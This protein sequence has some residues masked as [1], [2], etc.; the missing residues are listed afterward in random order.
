MA[1][2]L[3]EKVEELTTV[4]EFTS[5]A[6]R[7]EGNTTLADHIDKLSDLAVKVLK[8]EA[9]KQELLSLWGEAPLRTSLYQTY[10]ME[11]TRRVINSLLGL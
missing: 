5:G 9:T 3:D 7:D 1:Q 8:G 6:C 4:L 10:T 11:H 2:T